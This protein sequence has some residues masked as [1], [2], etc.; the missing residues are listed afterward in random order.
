[1]LHRSLLKSIVN[2]LDY[3][4]Y[5]IVTASSFVQTSLKVT[6]EVVK[7]SDIVKP[8][9]DDTFQKLYNAGSQTDWSKRSNIT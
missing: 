6:E 9:D 7:F 1:M 4:K 2:G 3:L 5:L 8:V